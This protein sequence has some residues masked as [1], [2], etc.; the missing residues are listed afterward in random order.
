MFAG[1]A[2][3]KKAGMIRPDGSLTFVF[4]CDRMRQ[5]NGAVIPG[6]PGG[7]GENREGRRM[8]TGVVVAIATVI[9]V[10]VIAVIICVV[11]AV[12]SVTGIRQTNAED[13][14]T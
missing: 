3:G 10:A 6:E 7:E 2:G 13:S 14:E 5:M 9:S 12:S 1:S 8:E 11:A 4:F